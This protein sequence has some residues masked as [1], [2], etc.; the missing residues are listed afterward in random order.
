MKR[1]AVLWIVAFVVTL[2]SAYYQRVTGPT[3]PVSGTVTLQGQEIR[4]RLDHSHMGETND[5]IEIRVPDSLTRGEILWRRHKTDDPL[6]TVMMVYHDG[7]LHGELPAQPPAG[8]LNYRVFLEREGERVQLHEP[9][10]VVIRF[11]G[12]V[13][14]WLLILHVT[15]MFSAMLFSTRAGLEFFAPEP[16]LKPLILWTIA[17][18]F[19]GGFIL[20]PAVQQYAFNAW[21]TGWPFGTDLTDNKTALALLAWILALVA[22]SRSR[23]PRT[24]ALVAAIV[25]LLVYLIPHSVLGSELD[26]KT[27]DKEQS[28]TET[29]RTP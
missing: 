5:V 14:L 11:T 13:P 15:A 27:L 2:L 8:K 21:W 26:Y 17:T 16:K 9:D 28:G 20:G 10:P 19:V 23:K 22:L 6:D 1:P 25:T 24:W 29:V 4:Y 18:L 12:T 3:Y 7:V